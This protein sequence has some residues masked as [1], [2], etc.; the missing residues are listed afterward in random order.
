MLTDS[1]TTGLYKFMVDSTVMESQARAVN[2]AALKANLISPSFTTPNI[3]AASGSLLNLGGNDVKLYS[4]ISTDY[5]ISI[6]RT[7]TGSTNKHGFGDLSTLN[8][9]GS[10]VGYA[11][12]DAR[13]TVGDNVKMDHITNY[14]G[15]VTFGINDTLSNHFGFGNSPTLSA[16]AHI[17][18]RYGVYIE[19]FGAGTIRKNVGVYIAPTFL[20]SDVD[21]NFSILAEKG[22]VVLKDNP[23]VTTKY[24]MM[25]LGSMPYDGVTSGFFTGHTNGT[26]IGINSRADFI[27]DLLQMQVTGVPKFGVGA[28]GKVGIGIATVGISE[29]LHINNPALTSSSKIM[30]TTGSLP[31]TSNAPTIGLNSANTFELMYKAGGN[32]AIGTNNT[33]RMR[34]SGTGQV[35]IGVT[36]PTSILHTTSFATAYT[37]SA[38]DITLTVVHNVVVLTA[39]TLTATLP[40]AV[41]ITGRIYTIKLTASGTG[42]VA[43]TSSQTIDGS[44]TYSLSAQYKYVTVQNNGASWNIIGNN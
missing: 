33:E 9:S 4:G 22:R 1:A 35:G 14:Q 40:T 39:T 2:R 34:V 28:N 43:T 36:S 31:S 17:N 27:G 15:I 10:T 23:I 19:Q 32:I 16:G 8:F 12:F 5:P 18:S 26:Y 38:V 25:A 29:L 24:P 21:S 6:N 30:F 7:L 11:P 3:G 44:T 41:G 13:L 20:S 37:A 42:V